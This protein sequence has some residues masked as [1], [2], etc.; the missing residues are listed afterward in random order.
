MRSCGTTVTLKLRMKHNSQMAW[1]S[2][3]GVKTF[4]TPPDFLGTL[5]HCCSAC[6]GNQEPWSPACGRCGLWTP[7]LLC[8]GR[9]HMG[10][11]YPVSRR[12]FHSPGAQASP[13]PSP[14]GPQFSCFPVTQSDTQ[15]LVR[16][17]TPL[18]ALRSA[19][20]FGPT[21]LLQQG[22]AGCLLP[23]CVC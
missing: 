7:A 2:I 1:V 11:L 13:A 17:Q 5:S 10:V 9:E 18:V 6:V 16:G 23:L 22:L 12:D 8:V 21:V 19:G 4:L 14:P 15:S 3:P 20:G